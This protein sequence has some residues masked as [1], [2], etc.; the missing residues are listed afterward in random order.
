[1]SVRVRNRLFYILAAAA[2]T[3]AAA[4]L[5]SVPAFGAVI[6]TA[7][8]TVSADGVFPP[9]G[10]DA[11]PVVPDG[12][13]LSYAGSVGSVSRSEDGTVAVVLTGG[14]GTSAGRDGKEDSSRAGVVSVTERIDLG[15]WDRLSFGAFIR[16]GEDGIRSCRLIVSVYSPS[17]TLR[18]ETELRRGAPTASVFDIGRLGDR[19][20]IRR[21]SFTFEWQSTDGEPGEIVLSRLCGS[22]DAP[23][24]AVTSSLSFCPVAGALHGAD[25][26]LSAVPEDGTASV[27]F[28]IDPDAAKAEGG[29][30]GEVPV[31]YAALTLSG[32]GGTVTAEFDPP[33][34]SEPPDL[35][36]PN[37]R[38]VAEGVFT[39]MFRFVAD[40]VKTVRFTFRNNDGGAFTIESLRFFPAGFTD[41]HLEDIGAVIDCEL[42]DG[43]LFVEGKLKKSSAVDYMGG[44]IGLYTAPA[45][46]GEP[47]LLATGRAGSA[48]SFTVPASSLPGGGRENYFWV[49]VLGN[50]G[51]DIPLTEKKF[52]SSATVSEG[53]SAVFGLYGAE[54]AGVF[55]AG[56]KRA[57]IDVRLDR[58]TGGGHSLTTG[59]SARR[60]SKTYYLN[61]EYVRRLD[62]ETEFYSAADIGVYLR[63]IPDDPAEWFRRDAVAREGDDPRDLDLYLALVSFFCGRY[64]NVASVVIPDLSSLYDFDGSE[65]TN[66]EAEALLARLT[67]GAAADATGSFIVTVPVRGAGRSPKGEIFA[68]LLSESL[69]RIGPIP[70]SLMDEESEGAFDGLDLSIASMRSNGTS[71]PSFSALFWRPSG[72]PAPEAVAR[73]SELCDTARAKGSRAVILSFSDLSETSLFDY[74]AFRG[75]VTASEGEVFAALDLS[76]VVEIASSSVLFD[77]S[78][79]YSAQGFVAGSGLGSCGTSFSSGRTGDRVLRFTLDRESS[80]GILLRQFAKPVNF[81]Q[82]P[83][84]EFDIDVVSDEGAVITFLFRRDDGTAEY[85][86][87]CP[88]GETS[89]RAVCDM[90][91]L[92]AA[93][94]VSC[95]S[96]LVRSSGTVRADLSRVTA[97]SRTVRDGSF[98]I[99]P[100]SG[101]DEKGETAD[102]RTV[103]L[104]VSSAAVALIPLGIYCFRFDRDAASAPVKPTENRRNKGR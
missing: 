16:A 86:L 13:K 41:P 77:F 47:V 10:E 94:S 29:E 5:L 54:P 63:F 46:G 33:A 45:A 97:H 74:S 2:A 75:A 40:E 48:F 95:I 81:S 6:P 7:G 23:A 96:I 21:I 66:A 57:I 3:A 19:S 80:L 24:P 36:S 69:S 82:F 30:D 56:M 98:S 27:L 91:D 9:D 62:S 22:K 79:S 14:G 67:Y 100:K 52:I 92:D 39:Y 35:S 8:G 59:L 72:V 11:V 73:L 32:G 64:E 104:I 26:K 70:W 55:E 49:S 38:N 18:Y 20:A 43:T 68:S 99:E 17:D 76:D 90:S 1:M 102:G 31:R 28:F 101:A 84:V 88:A 60:G 51:N 87:E 78:D 71:T 89:R 61:D 34:G 85:V 58:L 4:L 65:W 37:T 93:G 44:K 15:D 103:F 12:A 42:R 53:S 50:D 25:G 83:V